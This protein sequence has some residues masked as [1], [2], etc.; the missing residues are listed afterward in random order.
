VF[1]GDNG[2]GKGTVS[3]FNGKPYP[4]GKGLSTRAGMHVPLIVNWRGKIAA[5]KTCDDLID[6][7]DILPTICDAAGIKPPSPIDGRIFWPQLKGERGQ[8]REWFYSWFSRD[9]L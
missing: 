5:G 3:M 8:P 9:G 6:S 1:L 7:T 2:T 4:G